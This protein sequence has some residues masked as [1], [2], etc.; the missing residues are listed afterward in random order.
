M[1]S[2]NLQ[3]SINVLRPIGGGLL[4]LVAFD[5]IASL[6]PSNFFSPTWE[7]N[8]VGN[9]V[10]RLPLILL[11][12]AAIFWGDREVKNQKDKLIWQSLRWLI[13]LIAIL[14]LLMAPSIVVNS[15]RI[16]NQ[17]DARVTAEVTQRLANL[18]K[19]EGQIK[20]GNPVDL[21]NA[22]LQI[23][24]QVNVTNLTP[25]EVRE[26]LL[27]EIATEKQNARKNVAVRWEPNR[28]EL[29]K[30]TVKWFLGSIVGATLL[31]WMWRVTV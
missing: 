17:T 14:F 19:L 3:T 16:K 25:E 1:R 24:T 27:Q 8:T 22:I 5:T 7:F 6:I 4:L 30:N 21:K 13:L 29:V 31:F 20:Q 18:D 12:F 28:L 26:K 10:N 11:G 23:N 9:L 2:Q 15:S